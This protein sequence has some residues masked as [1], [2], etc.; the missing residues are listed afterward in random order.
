M[1]LA[2]ARS[3]V[4]LALG[5]MNTLYQQPVFDEWM[6]VKLSP[7]QSAVLAYQGPRA[8]SFQRK[9]KEDVAPLRAELEQR[10][11][12]VGD[13]G[14][15]QDAAGTRFDGC[16]RVGP[17]SYFLCNNTLKTME[18]VRKSPLWLSAQKPFADL[19]DKFR[20]DPLT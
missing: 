15:V 17:A 19:G 20:A 9:F 4:T 13:F 5:R 1:N 14:F 3:A 12:A 7:A 16:M 11:L 6:V 2:D 10:K 8:E 18:E